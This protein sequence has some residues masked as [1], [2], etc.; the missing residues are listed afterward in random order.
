[1]KP[2]SDP[3]ILAIDVRRNRFGYALFEGPKHLLV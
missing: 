2:H 1:M 3:R